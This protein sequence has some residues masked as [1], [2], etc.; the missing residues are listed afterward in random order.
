MTTTAESPETTTAA[1]ALSPWHGVADTAER[2]HWEAVAA[3]VGARLGTDALERDRAN[4][5]GRAHV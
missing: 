2:A 1:A 4:Q 3:E 5:I